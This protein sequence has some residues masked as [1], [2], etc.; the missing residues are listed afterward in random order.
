VS[1]AETPRNWEQGEKPNYAQKATTAG[2]SSLRRPTKSATAKLVD[3]PQGKPAAM[4]HFVPAPHLPLTGSNSPRNSQRKPL[5]L[6]P[7]K[8]APRETNSQT[9]ANSPAQAPSQSIP[10]AMERA[11]PATG[12]AQ[13]LSSFTQSET[14]GDAFE[15]ALGVSGFQWPETCDRLER[16]FPPDYSALHHLLEARRGEY[17]PVIAVT[18][19]QRGEGRST[20]LLCLGR[21]LARAGVRTV[22]VDGDFAHPALAEQLG[23]ETSIGWEDVLTGQL[24]LSEAVVL[25][26]REGLSLL[27]SSETASDCHALASRLHVTISLAVLSQHYDVVLVDTGPLCDEPSSAATM[28]R[29]AKFTGALLVH[30]TRTA[31]EQTVAPAIARLTE[32]HVPLLG[33]VENFGGEME[34]I[35]LNDKRTAA[36]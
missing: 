12:S 3:I 19:A 22:M 14:V 15:P 29:R 23:L 28:L 9:Q 34:H 7:S 18:G 30:D 4:T 10:A 36:A 25:A 32:L 11:Q 13:P 17:A 20:T 27:P 35:P 6:G 8:E 24:L 5:N 16:F 33:V 1:K 31:V 26:E 21:E 2:Q